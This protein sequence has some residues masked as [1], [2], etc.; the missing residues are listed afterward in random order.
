MDHFNFRR[1]AL[2]GIALLATAGMATFAAAQAP[3]RIGALLDVTGA[4]SFLGKPEQNAVTLAIEQANAAGGIRGRKIEL[5]FEDAKSTETD[6]VLGAR[7]LITQS[8]VAA[9]IGTSRTGGAM[10]ILPIATEAGVP[11][12]APVSGVAVVEPV[13]ERKWIFRPGQGGDLSV[14]KVIEYARRAGWKKLGVLHSADAYGEDGRDNMR[15]LAPAAGVSIAR[16]ESFPASAT[17]LKPQLTKL[18]AGGVDAIFMHG[19][20]AP[21]VIVYRNASELGLKPPLI[22]GHGQANSAFRNAVGNVVNGQP[23][24][25]APVLVWN[26]LP[27]AHPQ[28]QV[29]AAFVGAYTKRFGAAPDMFAGVAY[30]SAQMVLQAIRETDGERA[31]IR[32]W[33]ESKVRNYVGVTGV[34]NFSPTDHAGL[35]SDALVMMIATENG[36]RLA[37]FEK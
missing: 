12:L 10:A 18:A 21:S 6:S 30:D 7:R 3:Y 36:W 28:K 20:G 24:V 22:S 2:R 34:F 13:A 8:K 37:D 26:E 14:A 9:L 4:A 16:E 19:L 15:K 31:S 25:G 17:D 35:K 29:A 5:V 1:F 27:D 11:M 33:L 23:I 32:N